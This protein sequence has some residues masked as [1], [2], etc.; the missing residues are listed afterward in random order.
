MFIKS[1]IEELLVIRML[2][3]VSSLFGFNPEGGL[4]ER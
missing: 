4:N 1:F 3:K 2:S